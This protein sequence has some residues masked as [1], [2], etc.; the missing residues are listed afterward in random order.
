MEPPLL[1]VEP[2]HRMRC[3]LAEDTMATEQ[4]G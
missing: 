4:P 1:P 3:W 2:E